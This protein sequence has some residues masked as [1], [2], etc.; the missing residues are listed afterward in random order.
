MIIKNRSPLFKRGTILDKEILE[1][2]RSDVREY[3]DMKYKKNSVGV[4]EGFDI[5]VKEEVL[6]VEE[7]IFKWDGK[8]YK[9]SKLINIDIPEKDGDYYLKIKFHEEK[10]LGKFLCNYFE[11]VLTTEKVEKN[12]LE[13]ARI[14]KREGAEIRNYQKYQGIDKEYNQINIIHQ[15]QS[16]KTGTSLNYKILKLFS[17]EML[18]E[19]ELLEL[20]KIIC[21]MILEEKFERES[22]N[23]YLS[24]KIN[25][26]SEEL[27]SEDIYIILEKILRN[28][29]N[30]KNIIKNN[31][32]SKNKIMVE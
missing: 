28:S 24:E 5:G 12:E 15:L 2:L 11:I 7:G 27:S 21:F 29:K 32:K 19:K 30:R 25:I 17:Q 16:T 1:Y 8:T 3:F 18:N 22:L 26:E 23:K 13:L 6:H 9:L 14:K 4:I 20:D 31:F 10:E